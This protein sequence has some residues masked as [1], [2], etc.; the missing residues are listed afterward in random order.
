MGV[1]YL[2]AIL[3]IG[4]I[5]AVSA[6]HDDD[7][8]AVLRRLAEVE[9]E[10]AKSQETIEALREEVDTLRAV[11]DD[12]WLTER[13]AAEIRA[14]VSDVLADADARISV[15]Q[16]S[17][18]PMH[19]P[20]FPE[21]ANE[22]KFI[23]RSQ[24]GDFELGV[25]GLIIFRYEYN[26]R[27]D[28]G[29]GTS[30]N[31]QGFQL[32][33][34]RINLRGHVYKNWGYW[35]R[36]NADNPATGNDLFVDAAMGMYYFDKDTTLVFGQFPSLLTRSQGSPVDWLQTTESSPTNYVFD[37]FGFQG[38]MLGL[39]SPKLVFRG[40]ISDG[41]RS[42]N[43]TIFDS[44]SADWGLGGQ[45]LW[46]AFGNEDDWPRFNTFTSR[47]DSGDFAWLLNAALYGQQGATNID[48]AGRGSDLFLAIFES[49]MEGS[50]W[51]TY[52]AFYYRYTDP[53]S[54]GIRAN[55][56][57][58]VLQAGGWVA[59]HVELYS[60]FDMTIPDKDRLTQG[61]D[62]RTLTTGVAYY[63]I[64]SSDNLKFSTELSYMFDAEASS[65]VEPN[66]F[67]GVLASPAGDQVVLRAQFHIRW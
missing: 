31:D 49:S 60:R 27:R 13:R 10:Q 20:A 63:P 65:L 61:D 1:R 6:A 62:F 39:H 29:T 33:G 19:R 17:L 66:V 46:M 43:N 7:L 38:V 51:N 34:L 35:V 36:L 24:D 30:G 9:A 64:A 37:P 12:N 52:G 4:M 23:I 55:D 47:R 25:D 42:A 58:F 48:P 18:G 45:L 40:I 16:T 50:G 54:E 44:A 5:T 8:D 67:T 41:Y 21:L 53:G 2:L 32:T 3:V 15:L 28:D 56:F 11:N 26:H 22:S 57:G 59:E 14:L